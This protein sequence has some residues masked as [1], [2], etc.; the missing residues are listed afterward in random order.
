MYSISV[1]QKISTININLIRTDHKLRNIKI[2]EI[3]AF[4]RDSLLSPGGRYAIDVTHIST[5][6]IEVTSAFP[7]FF[8]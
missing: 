7:T 6:T 3:S 1:K 4:L 5:A 2:I 8:L